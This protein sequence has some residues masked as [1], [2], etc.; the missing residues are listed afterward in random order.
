MNADSQPRIGID[1]FLARRWVDRALS[2]RGSIDDPEEC[3]R[4]FIDWLSQEIQG[5]EALRKTENQIRR[6]W[7]VDDDVATVLRRRA[8]SLASSG[9]DVETMILQLGMA[10]TVFPGFH[11][12]SVAAG[13]LAAIQGE[14][15]STEVTDRVTEKFANP[16]SIPRT[17]N[18]ILQTLLDWGFVGK[19]L[20]FFSLVPAS[21][22]N[23]RIAEWLMIALLT[24]RQDGPVSLAE[25]GSLPE[26]LG[27]QIPN[28]REI[29]QN[30]HIL[31]IVRNGSSTEMVKIRPDDPRGTIYQSL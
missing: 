10:N 14:F 24:A 9:S 6:M 15:T 21:I 30:S 2:L 20:R 27:V 11:E 4:L 28:G 1:R 7:L 8:I 12:V 18:R 5:K 22:S 31:T 16:N 3:R 29:I 17:V 25:L 19:R 23:A 13:R 26:L